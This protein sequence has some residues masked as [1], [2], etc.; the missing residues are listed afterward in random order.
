M[1]KSIEKSVLFILLTILIVG[2]IMNRKEELTKLGNRIRDVRY[3]QHL[4][5]SELASYC[6]LN[7]NYIGMLERGERNPTYITLLGI[8]K[9]LKLSIVELIG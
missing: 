3:Q 5:Q 8:A 6:G 7:R 2:I 4:T 1:I 9:K